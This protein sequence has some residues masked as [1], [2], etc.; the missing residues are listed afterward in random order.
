MIDEG[1]RAQFPGARGYLD[2]ASLGL[3]PRVTVEAMTGALSEW[4]S[5]AATARGYDRYVAEARELFAA[6]V[7][8]PSAQVAIGAQVSALV[9]MAV[10]A[11]PHGARVVLP[12]GE[13]T[14]VVFPFLARPDLELEVVTAPLERLAEA[15]DPGT[16]M[17]AFSLVQSAD[18]RVADLPAV[19]SAARAAGALTLA[20]GTQAAGW[21]PFAAG[22]YD[23]TV[24]GGYKWLLCPRGTAF[25]TV[26]AD[27]LERIQ[28]VYAGWYSGADPW[29]SIYGLPLR[30][31]PDASRLDLSPAWHAWVGSAAS[32]RLLADLG[33]ESVH[34]HDVSLANAARAGLGLPPGDSAMVSLE[35]EPDFDK[36]RLEG[37]R[38]SYRAGRLRVAFHLYNSAQDVER[39][40]TAIAG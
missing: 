17:V 25:M 4:Q 2:T 12:E 20:D 11:L 13:F 37:L 28:P 34:A 19:R 26:R 16:A 22:D 29:D 1:L 35:L 10:T 18:G 14:S 36:A 30:L 24:T 3:P 31:A 33:V 38:T 32:L 5:G 6:M 15:I 8:V 9:G 7:S 23:I 40:V 27:L 39:L 21:L